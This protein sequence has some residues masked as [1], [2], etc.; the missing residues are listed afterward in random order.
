[1]CRLPKLKVISPFR[2]KNEIYELEQAKDILFHYDDIPM[3]V[4]IEGQLIKSYKELVELVG[5]DQY[6]YKECIEVRE[7]PVMLAGG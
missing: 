4:I 3:H 5:Q 7:V 1:M 2:Y 6:R